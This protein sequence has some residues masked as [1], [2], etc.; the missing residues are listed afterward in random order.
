M[1]ATVGCGRG[2][3]RTLLI[4][5]H[6]DMIPVRST[7]PPRQVPVVNYTLIGA[8]LA[9]FAYET[10]LGARFEPFVWMGPCEFFPRLG[11]G[12]GSGDHTARGQVCCC[13]GA[14]CVSVAT[15]C[16]SGGKVDDRRGAV[17]GTSASTV[18]VV[19]WQCLCRFV[20]RPPCISP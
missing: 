7:T 12:V 4:L 10:M 14:G 20:S 16:S 19:R 5:W 9:C 2:T 3:T 17:C 11:A 18:L 8:N 15:S 6:G 1:L 13:T